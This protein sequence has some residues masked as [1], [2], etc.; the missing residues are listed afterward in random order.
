VIVVEQ[1]AIAASRT[2]DRCTILDNG[3]VVL[4]GAASEVRENQELRK[5]YLAI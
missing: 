3:A 2:A 5:A 4:H 1:I